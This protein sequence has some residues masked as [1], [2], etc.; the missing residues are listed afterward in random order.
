[1]DTVKKEVESLVQELKNPKTNLT[2][3]RAIADE[4]GKNTDLADAL[5]ATGIIKARLLSLLLFDLK[6][7]DEKRIDSMIADIEKAPEKDQVQL[8]DWLL[9]NVIMKKNP[10]KKQVAGW[11]SE[12]SL[13]KQRLYW[14]FRAKTIGA[15]D[16]ELNLQLLDYLENHIVDAPPLVQ[17]TM[18]WCIASIGIQDE[19]LR[20]RCIRIGEK[21]GLY[22]DYP[23]SK[24]CTSPYLP[25][26]INAVV[27]KKNKK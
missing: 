5:W 13:I 8:S 25:I 20:E 11:A 23:V 21:N 26:W 12:N 24:G 16:K 14:Q 22:K 2:R 15:E 1:M 10:L 4:T 27:N 18:N 17:W 19:T 3:I 9:S 7:V 6:T